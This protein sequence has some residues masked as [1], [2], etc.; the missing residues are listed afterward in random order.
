M[1]KGKEGL[2]LVIGG[3]KG[4]ETPKEDKEKGN[5]DM[6]KEQA[7]KALIKGVKNGDWEAVESAMQAHYDACSGGGSE[8]Y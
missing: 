4:K 1:A 7:A 5:A 8:D 3:P 2:L 6:A